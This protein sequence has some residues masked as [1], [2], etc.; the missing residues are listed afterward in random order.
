MFVLNSFILLLFGFD[1]LP[2]YHSPLFFQCLLFKKNLTFFYMLFSCECYLQVS[3]VFGIKAVYR[4][5][6]L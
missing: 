1:F 2:V 5:R 4:S 6:I 3:N